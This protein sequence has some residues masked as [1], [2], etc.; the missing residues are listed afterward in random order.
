VIDLGGF[1]CASSGDQQR[2]KATQETSR[3]V[4]KEQREKITVCIEA[5]ENS[6][7]CK[8]RSRTLSNSRRILLARQRFTALKETAL[9]DKEVL[10]SLI[11]D[12]QRCNNENL[13]LKYL[14]DGATYFECTRGLRG[15]RPQEAAEFVTH[16][17]TPITPADATDARKGSVAVVS[18]AQRACRSNVSL[19]EQAKEQLSIGRQIQQSIQILSA[20]I[21][22][23]ERL[24]CAMDAEISLKVGQGESYDIALWLVSTKAGTV[25][26]RGPSPIYC[27]KYI[28]TGVVC[29]RV[30]SP[31]WRKLSR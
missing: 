10:K 29:R 21:N 6:D 7:P 9:K 14:L 30:K 25:M 16:S 8:F 20:N 26:K 11:L 17:S 5:W 13:S 31:V 4:A 24:T 3:K 22:E 19:H 12:V 28:C 15:L 27:T 23:V 2:R 18:S 1:L